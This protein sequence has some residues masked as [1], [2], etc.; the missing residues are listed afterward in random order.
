MEMSFFDLVSGDGWGLGTALFGTLGDG[1]GFA[2]ASTDGKTSDGLGIA[3]GI[4]GTLSGLGGLFAGVGKLGKREKWDGGWDIA[5]NAFTTA[6][7]AADIATGSYGIQAANAD[8]ET[9]RERYTRNKGVA[10]MWSGH[11][12][13]LGGLV[14]SARGIGDLIKNW[15]DK[16]PEGKQKKLDAGLGI[17]GGLGKIANGVGNIY[18]GRYTRDDPLATDQNLDGKR[19]FWGNYRKLATG[20]G[21]LPGAISS[22]KA[23][24][25]LTEAGD[26]AAEGQTDQQNG[27]NT[28][29]QSESSDGEDAES[30]PV[31][32]EEDAGI[33]TESP[34]R[35]GEESQT[36]SPERKD[37]ESQ[38]ESPERKDEESQTESP[39]RRDEEIQTNPPGRR[40]VEIRR[41]S[42]G[43]DTGIVDVHTVSFSA[44]HP[45]SNQRG[46]VPK[47]KTTLR[48][49]G[50]T[51]IQSSGGRD[52][53][54]TGNLF[55]T[56]EDGKMWYGN[57]GTL[58]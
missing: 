44:S 39:E 21:M 31:L 42:L 23:A 49:A 37:E 32:L 22:Y 40:D 1:L 45:K 11:L 2:S 17:L 16:S 33:Q 57:R 46:G 34:E 14:S 25:K 43:R 6:V 18:Q 7:G 30:E 47:P 41:E 58:L 56:F 35:K 10:Q 24:K 53:G 51:I 19:S 38:T 50:A 8:S 26:A 3:S 5:E 9:D 55:P 15:K 13:V 28:E 52:R 12:G 48:K 54:R 20:F 36:E 4:S 27:E 29:S